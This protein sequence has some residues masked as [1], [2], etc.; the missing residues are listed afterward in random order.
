[1][2]VVLE[3]ELNSTS[4]GLID[5]LGTAER[6]VIERVLISTRGNITQ[7]AKLL[8]I[9]RQSLQRKIAKLGIVIKKRAN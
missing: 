7:A 3:L 6:A 2:V 4:Q 8:G 9:Q 1:V 5:V